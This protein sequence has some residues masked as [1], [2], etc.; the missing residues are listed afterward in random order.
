MWIEI[1]ILIKRNILKIQLFWSALKLAEIKKKQFSSLRHLKLHALQS[2]SG[3]QPVTGGSSHSEVFLRK[4][5]LK[6]CSEFKGQHPCRSTI[7]IKLLCNFIEIALRHGRSPVN[8][9]HIFRRP[10]PR[11][12]SGWLLLHRGFWSSALRRKFNSCFS[13]VFC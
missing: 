2:S 13:R 8:L 4:G 5:V 3:L 11:K 12:A 6:I 10:F 9:L 1:Q 7:S